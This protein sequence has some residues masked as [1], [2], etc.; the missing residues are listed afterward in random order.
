MFYKK[1][2][3]SRFH[4][5]II[6]HKLICSVQRNA[7]HIKGKVLDTGCG[8]TPYKDTLKKHY[9]EY[10][11]LD[12]INIDH[13][14]S[15]VDIVANATSLPF[16]DSSFD[17]IVSFQVME[18]V[19]EPKKFLREGFRVLKEGGYMLLSTPFMWGE[20][21]PP[22]DYYRYT[23]YG[24]RYL[25]EQAGFEVINIVAETGFWVMSVLRFNY[26]INN[27]AKG[28]LKYLLIPLFYLNQSIA[29]LMDRI[30]SSYTLDTAVFTTLLKKH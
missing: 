7:E 18:H 30:F 22:Y 16:K 17:S 21:E 3:N 4:N 28:P 14:L 20:H 12:H 10:I 23:R 1:N 8:K 15:E 13:E 26:W 5:W 24:L 29:S 6:H 25:A 27:F 11:R 9:S 19:P 2:S